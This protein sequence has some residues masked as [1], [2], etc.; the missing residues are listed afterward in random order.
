MV[1]VAV[2]VGEGFIVWVGVSVAGKVGIAV[3]V[4]G[5]VAV[6]TSVRV[7]VGVG[8]TLRSGASATAT[9]PMQ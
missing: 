8:K 7:E 3:R 6:A 9:S 1:S 5:R 4:G 2:V